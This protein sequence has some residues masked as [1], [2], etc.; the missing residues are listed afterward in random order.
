MIFIGEIAALSAALFWAAN[1]IVLTEATI[2]IGSVA[3]N[4]SR[5][6]MASILLLLT[7]LLVG[8]SFDISDRQLIYLVISGVLGLIIGD[9]ALFKS[10]QLIG[11]RLGMLLMSLAPPI[12]ALLAFIFLD[13]YLSVWGVVGIFV[14]VIGVSLVVLER[15]PNRNTGSHF[16]FKGIVFGIIAATGQAT[17]LIFAKQA[18]NESPLNEFTVSFIRLF[19][20][21][22][23]MYIIFRSMGKFKNPVRMFKNDPYALKH[24]IAASILGPYLGITAS[25]I[26][27]NNTYV[28]IAST[29]M[30]TV[31]IVML[32]MV[33]FYYKEKLSPTAIFGAVIAVAGI[34][35]L[36]LK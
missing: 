9:T 34:S 20:A 24:T 21:T 23:L 5:M 8:A 35:I 13:E 10:F 7:T 32:P 12:A 29:L 36:F 27:I 31:P 16:N 33:R 28:G 14:T 18:F 30:A 22:V 11:P 2:R 3:V 15:N 25:M 17:G 6:F 19:S 1:S 4:I 26:A